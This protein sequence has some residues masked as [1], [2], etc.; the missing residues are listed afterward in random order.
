HALDS[1]FAGLV[2]AA[3]Y[4]LHPALHG[5]N[6]YEFHSLTLVAPPMLWALFFLET[7]RFK[8]YWATFALLL[9]VREDVSLLLAF[10]GVYALLR[11]D[12]A[13]H[14]AGWVTL[15]ICLFY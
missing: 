3:A 13:H 8:S 9:L 1:R 11:D 12:K 2:T 10:V 7:K 6:L 5:P 15:G 4:G 14:R